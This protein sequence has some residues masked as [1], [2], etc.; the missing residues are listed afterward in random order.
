MPA[1]P[2][3]AGVRQAGYSMYVSNM[4]TCV[5]LI[6]VHTYVYMPVLKSRNYVSHFAYTFA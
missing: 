3:S 1:F 4:H 5:K 6:R 2:D